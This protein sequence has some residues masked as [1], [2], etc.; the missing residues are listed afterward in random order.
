M[1]KIEESE[2]V[3]VI[4]SHARK[5]KNTI[6]EVTLTAS[7]EHVWILYYQMFCQDSEGKP[8]YVMDVC[9]VYKTRAKAREVIKYI[10]ATPEYKADV[11][12]C[13]KVRVFAQKY[14]VLI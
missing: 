2:P 12:N 9:G 6:A 8:T 3:E 14:M 7:N 11:K 4:K 13:K 10:K 5:K 1:I